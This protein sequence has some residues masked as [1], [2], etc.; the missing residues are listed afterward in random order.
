MVLKT[1]DSEQR[2]ART[3]TLI[4]LGGLL[5]L[6]PIVKICDIKMGEDL[7]SSSDKASFLLGLL[8]RC[9]ELI[10][11]SLKEKEIEALKAIG[12]TML[13]KR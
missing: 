9:C 2:K 6:T 10:P 13:K 1:K 11:N 12:R 3:R 4:Q 8:Q 5:S 7:Q